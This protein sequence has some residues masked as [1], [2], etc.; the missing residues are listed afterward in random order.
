[1]NGCQSVSAALKRLPELD[2]ELFQKRAFPSNSIYDCFRLAGAALPVI[3]VAAITYFTADPPL[4]L[5]RRDGT[6]HGGVLG[7]IGNSVVVGSCY[8]SRVDEGSEVAIR[9]TDSSGKRGVWIGRYE[10]LNNVNPQ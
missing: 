1:M 3:E 5:D 4:L 8:V 2:P 6:Y 10:V 7:K 9:P